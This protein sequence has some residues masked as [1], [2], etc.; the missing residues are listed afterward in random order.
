MLNGYS[1]DVN[2]H[3]VIDERNHEMHQVI[4]AILRVEPDKLNV[5]VAW[6][7]KFLAAPEYSPSGST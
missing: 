3:E 2:W 6:I 5:V 7:E 4:A 1:G